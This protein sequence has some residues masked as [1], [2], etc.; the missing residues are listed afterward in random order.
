MR[1]RI[2]LTWRTTPRQSSVRRRRRGADARDR[3]PDGLADDM[4]AN[5]ALVAAGRERGR[6]CARQRHRDR[7]RQARHRVLLLVR[8]ASW[9]QGVIHVR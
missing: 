5:D 4:V 6:D 2:V 3:T 9:M 1:L 8:G 7:D